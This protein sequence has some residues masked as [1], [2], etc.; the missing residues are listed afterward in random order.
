MFKTNL[1]AFLT[2]R[3]DPSA[4]SS[5]GGSSAITLAELFGVVNDNFGMQADDKL[6]TVLMNNIKENWV[7]TL[8]T[9]GGI[10]VADKVM[11]Q[12]GI[13]RNFNKVVRSVG[14]GQLVKV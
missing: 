6:S 10:K 14:L 7:Q 8:M 5:A 12:A 13:F 4:A 9:V 11:Q 2:E 1:P 3:W